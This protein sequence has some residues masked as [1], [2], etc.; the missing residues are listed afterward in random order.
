MKK[1][2]DYFDIGGAPGGNQDW[3]GDPMM[4]LGG[5][6]AVCA[7]DSC[8]YFALYKNAA[9]VYPFD[10]RALNRKDYVRFSRIMKPYLRPRREGVSD[11]QIYIDGFGAYL[12]GRPA[13]VSM[14]SLAGTRPV[15]DAAAA[16]SA[17]IGAGW[18][19]PCLTLSH[20]DREYADY[21]W[22]WFMLTGFDGDGADMRVR[23]VTYSEARWISLA[24]LWNT[25][26]ERRGGLILYGEPE[27]K[28]E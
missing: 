8:I 28:D 2:L 3:F 10:T 26:R 23:A 15:A 12:R 14:T 25:G 9:G 18:P 17:R 27:E 6:A 1:E 16:V 13:C 11:P 22:H 21:E 19:V 24:G 5:C 7:C 20:A 4:R